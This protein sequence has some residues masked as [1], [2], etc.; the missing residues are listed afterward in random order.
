MAICGKREAETNKISI[1]KHGTGNMGLLT[2]EE[3]VT[4]LKN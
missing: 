2:I 4:N 1:R 3:F